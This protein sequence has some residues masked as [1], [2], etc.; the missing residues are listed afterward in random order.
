VEFGD[1][2]CPYCARTASDLR[3]I[4]TKYGD[5]V[6]VVFRH[7]PLNQ[8]PEAVPAAEA[9]ECAAAQGHF[10]EFY[11]RAYE[12]QRYL[13]ERSLTWFA[14]S[15]GVT[16]TARFQACL[17]V[18]EGQ[19]AILR[20]IASAE[21]L[22]VTSTPTVFVNDRRIIVAPTMRLM[23]SLVEATLRRRNK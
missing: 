13:G 15:A 14:S 11:N 6:A 8:H 22:S 7:F 1:F 18:H 4:R 23:D 5:R 10:E 19:P 3:S 9:A 17:A 20:D 2:Q 21:S 12:Q 16:D